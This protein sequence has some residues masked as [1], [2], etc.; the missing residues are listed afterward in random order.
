MLGS[1]AVSDTYVFNVKG[2]TWGDHLFLADVVQG[3]TL[4]NGDTS[5]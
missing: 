2:L 4:T 3:T 1:F 5:R